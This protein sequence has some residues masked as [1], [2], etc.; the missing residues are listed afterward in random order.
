ME[1]DT[2]LYSLEAQRLRKEAEAIGLTLQEYL[3]LHLLDTLD[4]VEAITEEIADAEA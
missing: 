3:L 4:N 1:T 2:V